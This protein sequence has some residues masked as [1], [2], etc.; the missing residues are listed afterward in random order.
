MSLRSAQSDWRARW[1]TRPRYVR[2]FIWSPLDSFHVT[3]AYTTEYAEPVPTPP[4]SE[5]QHPVLNRT[6]NENPHLF[7]INTPI[8]VDRFES[9][10]SSHPNQPF[11][12]SVCVSMREGFW[13]WADARDADAPL[14]YDNSL[15]PLKDRSHA[16]FVRRQR[17]AEMSLG[18]FSPS[19]GTDLLPGMYS[20]PI[21]VVPKPHSSKLRM[22][23]D[24]SAEPYSPNSRIPKERRSLQ[25]DTLT[26]LGRSLR[27]VRRS[28]GTEIRLILFKSDVS[29]AYRLIPM[30]PLWQLMQIVT[31]DGLR[32]VD[33]D[34]EFGGGASGRIFWTFIS[35]VLWIAINVVCLEDLLGYVDDDYSWD[36]AQNMEWY[37][38]YSLFYPRKQTRLLRLW[39]YLG[40][41]H[42]QRKQVF[43]S[44]L[45]IIG[46]EVD[47]NAMTITMPDEARNDLI[48]A[49]ESFAIVGTR[50]SL[51]EYQ[52]LAGWVN[53]ALNAY[54][55]LRPG[56]CQLYQKMKGKS[57]PNMSVWVN[58]TLCKELAWIRN[59]LVLNDRPTRLLDAEEWPESDATVVLM[60]DACPT[61]MGFWCPTTALGFQCQVDPIA[62][63]NNYYEALAVLSALR[64]ALSLTDLDLSRLA[65][66]TDNFGTVE[67]FNSLRADAVFNPIVL[68]ACD[69]V[70]PTRCAL[71]VF[72]VPGYLNS[73]ADALSRFDHHA[74]CSLSPALTVLPF[75]PPRFTLG[76]ASQ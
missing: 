10:L 3:S 59:K 7:I 9:L 44:P 60:A 64:Y 38:P 76:A 41:P 29:R 23:F 55:L 62:H 73:I 61:G 5:L 13:P 67:I 8:H 37:E 70:W 39:D 75:Q 42:E 54:P 65:I 2:S 36:F 11:V 40:I 14:T 50:R 57:R 58:T 27:R 25:L 22:V 66:Y 18:Q 43:G 35:L 68:T 46:M 15:R 17:D 51:R 26:D 21:G 69:W 47:A 33:R 45:T 34:N 74:L 6:I 24:H 19:F 30:H 32:H 56:L 12:Q 49:I 53:W 48:A 71:R 72:H 1:G 28:L 52:Q 20:S 63:D 31:I 4:L 16:T